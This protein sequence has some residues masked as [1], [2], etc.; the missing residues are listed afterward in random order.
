MPV[1]NRKAAGQA[2]K[3]AA[4]DKA[5]AAREQEALEGQLDGAY[6]SESGSSFYDSGEDEDPIIMS[7][8]SDH[9]RI[10]C[11]MQLKPPTE[12]QA[13]GGKP[14]VNTGCSQ[15][16]QSRKKR[17]RKLASVGSQPITAHFLRVV[18]RG[19]NDDS[20]DEGD[21]S[22]GDCVD[23]Q[24]N[25]SCGSSAGTVIRSPTTLDEYTSP[26]PSRS[27]TRM[28]LC[29]AE[30]ATFEMYERGQLQPLSPRP[31]LLVSLTWI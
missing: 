31:Q 24:R 18:S 8:T 11:T 1:K 25:D 20:G 29:A 7:D 28:R 9:E 3:Q 12:K 21:E 2:N 16:S 14:L 10:L 15:R 5:A 4:L 22:T 30:L 13:S 17:Q 23:E 19:T 26:L 6:S 27:E